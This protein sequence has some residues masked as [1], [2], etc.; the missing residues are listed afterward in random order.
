ME[1]TKEVEKKGNIIEK[2]NIEN[3][4]IE[5]LTCKKNLRWEVSAQLGHNLLLFK[6]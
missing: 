1:K 6:H 4:K 2:V 3:L 5:K